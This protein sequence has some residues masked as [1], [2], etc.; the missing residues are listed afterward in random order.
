MTLNELLKSLGIED[1]TANKI[2]KGM[3]ENKLYVI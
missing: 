1:E 3:K 2:V